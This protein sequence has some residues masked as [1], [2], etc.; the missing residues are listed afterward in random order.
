CQVCELTAEYQ[1][2]ICRYYYCERHIRYGRLYGYNISKLNE[3]YC[4]A[5]WR[6]ER[7]NI[8][9]YKINKLKL[10][11]GLKKLEIKQGDTL[12]VQSS[13]SSFG[14]IEDGADALID[15]L[16]ILIGKNGT[17]AMPSFTPFA[18]RFHPRS[19]LVDRSCG[20]LPELFRK[21]YKTARSNNVKYSFASSGKYAVFI[22]NNAIK[23]ES[24][25]EL[26]PL[27]RIMNKS[28]KLLM[29]GVEFNNCIPLIFAENITSKH[30]GSSCGKKYFEIE[31][32]IRAL[33][34]YKEIIIGEALCRIMDI[35]ELVELVKCRIIE[36]PNIFNCY[37]SNCAKCSKQNKITSVLFE[38]NRIQIDKL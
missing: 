19:S 15:I 17:L 37:N 9:K 8:L 38:K 31:N 14:S 32:D 11:S 7:N 20:I 10:I 2:A 36:K 18:K 3:Y 30:S 29:L 22:I 35:K 16:L 33:N 26:S 28:G 12:F 34:S 24:L 27:Q 1:C 6:I 4:V 25:D 23:Y 13:V 21:R 5:C